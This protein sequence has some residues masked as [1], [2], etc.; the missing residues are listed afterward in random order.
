LQR[1]LKSFVNAEHRLEFVAEI[2]GIKFINDSKATNVDSVYYALEGVEAPIIWIAGGVDKG[3]DYKT[4]YPFLPK[5]KTLL[6]LGIKNQKLH[7]AF[8]SKVSKIKEF[9]DTK[10]LVKYA[11]QIGKPGDTVLL[12]PACASFDLFKN[13]MDRG[14]KFKEAVFSLQHQQTT[15]E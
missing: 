8:D 10:K 7:K 4:L 15:V 14:M 1:G 12:S 3:N 5:I 6:C 9:D 13:Y 11:L 2:D